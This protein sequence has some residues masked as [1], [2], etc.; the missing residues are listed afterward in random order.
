VTDTK[1]SAG[2]LLYRYREGAL[3]V[4]LVH[5][6]GP[7]WAAKDLGAW[8]VPKGLIDPGE[9]A[10]KAALREFRE[11]TGFI[12]RNHFIQLTPVR[13]KSGKVVKVWAVEGD[14][15]PSEI[16]SNAFSMEWPPGSGK[17][18]EFPEV[19]LA[20]W[21]DVD[22]ARKKINQGQ[23]GLLDELQILLSQSEVRMKE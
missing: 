4:L 10:L 7:F 8:S 12:A 20:A 17:Q 3:Q 13:M 2:I 19:D 1:T 14:C 15:E 16:K 23:V 9:D 5:P 11:E 6:G 18:Q 22:Q 21:F